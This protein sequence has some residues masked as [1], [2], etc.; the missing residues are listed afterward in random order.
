MEEEYFRLSLTPG[1]TF[2]GRKF[3]YLVFQYADELP[4]QGYFVARASEW[5]DAWK[6]CR[7]VSAQNCS[8]GKPYVYCEDGGKYQEDA[9]VFGVL[10]YGYIEFDRSGEE[11]T[12]NEG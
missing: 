3:D 1:S 12:T 5:G 4:E 7:V 10:K 6:L 8:T 2:V 11:D 9:F